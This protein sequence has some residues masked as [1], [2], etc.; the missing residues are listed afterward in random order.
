[1]F[2]FVQLFQEQPAVDLTERRSQGDPRVVIPVKPT[3]FRA[4]LETLPQQVKQPAVFHALV[5]AFAVR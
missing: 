5:E 3:A 1:M 4:A 2:Y